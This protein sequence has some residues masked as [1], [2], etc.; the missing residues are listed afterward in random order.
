[1]AVHLDSDPTDYDA[2]PHPA[3]AAQRQALSTLERQALDRLLDDM[4]N[5]RDESDSTSPTHVAVRAADLADW[6]DTLKALVAR[7]E[8]ETEPHP[9]ITP[10][11]P[12]DLP[13]DWPGEDAVEAF[14]EVYRQWRVSIG[15]PMDRPGP[16]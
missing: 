9:D 7:F 15:D 16:P 3:A 1:M 2:I 13:D 12:P 10:T 5:A 4:G 6:H 8:L 11:L 14:G